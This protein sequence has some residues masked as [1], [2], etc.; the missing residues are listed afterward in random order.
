[1]KGIIILL[2]KI[3]NFTISFRAETEATNKFQ[4]WT[5]WNGKI[6]GLTVDNSLIR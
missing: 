1:M 6:E 3:I 5:V 4:S 2:I